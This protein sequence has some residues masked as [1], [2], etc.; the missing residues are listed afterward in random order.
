MM[1]RKQAWIDKE[2]DLELLHLVFICLLIDDSEV[3]FLNMRRAVLENRNFSRAVMKMTHD[4]AMLTQF[5]DKMRAA[6]KGV[7]QRKK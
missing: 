3:V 7:A 1:T 6:Q 5:A 2:K 4:E